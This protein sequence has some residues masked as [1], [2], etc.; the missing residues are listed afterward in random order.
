[1]TDT[2]LHRSSAPTPPPRAAAAAT[3]PT[4]ACASTASP[5]SRSRSACSRSCSRRSSIGGYPAFTQTNIRVDFPVS[6][7]IV[8]PADPADGNFRAI[9]QAGVARCF[10]GARSRRRAARASTAILTAQHRS[11]SCATPSSRDP[12]V[13]GG[14]LTLEV[15][16]ADPFDQLAQ[17]R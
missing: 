13:I 2:A 5:R 3:P 11:S 10:P 17:G 7:E 16:A 1:M 14:T 4:A 12:A 6:A 8:D 15:P 9:V